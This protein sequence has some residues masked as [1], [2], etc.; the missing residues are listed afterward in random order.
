MTRST[1][2]DRPDALRRR[3]LAAGAGAMAAGALGGAS[4]ARA[5]A[6][7]AFD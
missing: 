3:L 1:H 2:D 4:F 5:Q 7:G 6:S